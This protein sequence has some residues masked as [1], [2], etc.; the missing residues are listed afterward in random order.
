M[1]FTGGVKGGQILDIKCR[2]SAPLW[3]WGGFNMGTMS[4]WA[5]AEWCSVYGLGADLG[6]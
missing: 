3:L 4:F 2:A 1:E 5:K 6:R